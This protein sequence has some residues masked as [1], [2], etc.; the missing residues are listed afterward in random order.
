MVKCASVLISNGKSL[1]PD[2]ILDMEIDQD[3]SK[4]TVAPLQETSARL[5]ID[6]K[7]GVLIAVGAG[8]YMSALDISVV[9]TVLPI[10]NKTFN[11][12]I[13]TV[14]WV[15]IIYLLLVSG[16]L[17]G[18]GRLGDLRGHKPVYIG[19]FILFIASSLLCAISPTILALI[20]AR[21]FQSIGASMLSANSPAIL[22]KTFPANQR[23]RALGLMATMTYLGLITGPSLGGW[24]AE[25]Y[26]WR[27]VF[28]INL[29][30]GLIALL[31]SIWFIQKDA[32]EKIAERFDWAGALT[33]LGGLVSLLLALNRG[34]D[35]GWTSPAILGLFAC[36]IVLL[37][38]FLWIESRV[39]APML[40]LSLF[41]IR[42]FSTSISSAV[43]N[44]VCVY[45][46]V[47]LMPFY[48]IQGR[49]LSPSQA[50]LLLTAQPI[51]MAIV[52]PISGTLSDT[53]GARIPGVTGMGILALGLFLLSR[54][55]I[56]SPPSMVAL[57][58][59]VC[60]LGIG[61][62]ISPNNSSLM[63][64]APRHRQGIAAGMLATARNVGMV[65]GVGLAGAIFTTVL[66]HGETGDQTVLYTA[67]QLSYSVIIFVALGGM[68]TSAIRGDDRNN[69]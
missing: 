6:R 38:V 34:H 10:V 9:N 48:L 33:F 59:A 42:S 55:N 58:L 2:I 52:A 39:R 49:G 5:N 8:T 19:G 54:L 30:V 16:M 64:S 40:D 56:A 26:G 14:E 65:L 12:D 60:G 31:L 63:G 29:P 36:A 68:L 57:S 15:V 46:I 37:G 41:R 24:L 3:K 28:Y 7:W 66:T 45:S 25:Y 61:T 23:G 13:A 67:V 50:G 18:F 35:W 22:T 27:S 11:S 47:F 32:P 43:L 53:I 44:Y 20:G 17:P 51:V 21:A 1:L 4:K 62:F 69:I